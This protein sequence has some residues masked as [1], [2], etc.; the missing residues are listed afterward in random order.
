MK[1]VLAILLALLMAASLFA[2]ASQNNGA[3]PAASS[4]AASSAAASTAPSSSAPAP[5]SGATAST[6]PSSSKF[7]K[8][9]GF[10]D[11]SFDYTKFKK[12]KVAFLCMTAGELWDAF[13]VAYANWSKKVNIDYHKLWAPTQYSA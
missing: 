8:E 10:Y 13:D 7:P 5:A 12:F 1:K 6:A 3:S 2:C 4:A 9:A 11:P